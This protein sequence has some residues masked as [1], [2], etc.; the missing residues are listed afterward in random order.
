MTNMTPYATDDIGTANHGS[1]LAYPERHIIGR[2]KAIQESQPGDAML[3]LSQTELQNR[4]NTSEEAALVINNNYQIIAT[5]S[6]FQARF[7]SADPNRLCHQASHGYAEPCHLSGESCPLKMAQERQSPQRVLHVHHSVE[8]AE[9][10]DIRLEPLWVEGLGA[11]YLETQQV[12]NQSGNSRYRLLGYSQIFTQTLELL[13]RAAP[14]DISVLI[15]GESGTG[16]ELAA[17]YLHFNSLR[18]RQ[19][20]VVVEC[21]GLTESLFESELFGHEKGAFTGANQAKPGLVEAADGGTLFLDEIGDVPLPLQVKLLRLIETGSYRR[22]GSVTERAANFRLISATHQNLE[23]LVAQG[24]FRQDLYYRINSFPVQ[25]PPLR[26]RVEDIPLI[27]ESYLSQWQHGA[28]TLS[29]AALRYLKSLDYPG[30]IR[31]LKNRLA[32]AAI[33]CDGEVV[34]PE[35]LQPP[36]GI[37]GKGRE[38]PEL[39]RTNGEQT[40]RTEPGWPET[41]L[42]LAE[43]EKL[44]LRYAVAHHRGDNRSLAKLLGVS[45]R[46]LYRKLNDL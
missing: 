12:V 40:S 24:L 17:R 32:R 4:L 9:H 10:V 2:T 1:H 46:T 45:E 23:A 44:Y 21:S 22:V 43:A 37:D 7:P 36:A 33:L 27:A 41:L 39:E 31:E 34:T 18:K 20:F 19:Q 8:G 26:E 29:A 11:V 28:K 5:N 14:N 16:K 15:T 42:T 35:Q 6:V 38:L 13:Q 30:N 25:L 3:T